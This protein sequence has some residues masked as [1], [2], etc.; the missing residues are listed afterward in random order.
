[1]EEGRQNQLGLL[2]V[3]GGV[4]GGLPVEV[5]V[6]G[7]AALGRRGLRRLE[8]HGR[9]GADDGVLRVD[10]GADLG[11]L[12]ADGGGGE[13]PVVL[14]TTA[15]AATTTRAVELVGEVEARGAAAEVEHGGVVGPRGGDGGGVEP[16]QIRDRL[17]GS[18]ISATH[19]PHFRIRTPRYCLPPPPPLPPTGALTAA[20]AACALRSSAAA[21][22][23]RRR[24]P[25][26]YPSSRNS[27]AAR[28]E[29]R[30]HLR[31]LAS[32][33]SPGEMSGGVYK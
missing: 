31:V 30:R 24:W 9:R 6:L 22:G 8:R 29:A 27:A 25:P 26:S 28:G 4:R 20:A 18:R 2:L 14:G 11:G 1:M 13:L 15:A 21:G 33:F 5:G 32:A 19:F 3:V 17:F 16:S 23:A 10:A 12:L 7:P